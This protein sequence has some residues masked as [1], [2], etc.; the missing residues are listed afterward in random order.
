VERRALQQLLEE[1]AS[2]AEIARRHGVHESTVGYWVTKH[3]LEAAHRKKHAARGGLRQEELEPLI[4][5]G[6]SI[7]QIAEAVG[8]SKGTVR[9]W[10]QRYGLRAS[11]RRG[12]RISDA[13]RLGKAAGLQTIVSECPRHG[14]AEF[15][16]DGRSYYRCKPCRAEAVARRRRKVKSILVAEA[17]GRCCICGYDRNMRALHFHHVDPAEKRVEI[18]A[19]GVALSL[20]S[21]R[22]EA[23]KCVLLCSNCHAE[24]E[25]GC[26]K[27]P[28]VVLDRYA[29]EVVEQP[30][31]SGSSHDPG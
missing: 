7:A 18:N 19:K 17:G 14:K 24:V 1:G 22:V 21:L 4:E 5:A 28:S 27:L 10:L 25:D 30:D 31:G 13:A 11:N 2:L 12:R 8:R 16:L 26:A 20:A 3:G 15:V 6:A 9:H 29:G 23:Q